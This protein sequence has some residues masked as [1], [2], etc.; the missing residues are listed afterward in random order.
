MNQHR[1]SV[2]IKRFAALAS[3]AA[4][5]LFNAGCASND[6]A[7]ADLLE[8]QLKIAAINGRIPLNQLASAPLDMN[9]EIEVTN[10]SQQEFVLK[11]LTIQSVGHGMYGVPSQTR[12]Y[13]EVIPGGATR[14]V[15][16]WFRAYL[17]SRNAAP[18]EG[19][20]MRGSMIFKTPFGSKRSN[21]LE[22]VTLGAFR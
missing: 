3:F 6:A 21:F 16:M 7:T 4:A 20:T 8:P 2:S 1:S 17:R 19:L 9:I 11:S 10:R 5:L 12:N 22:S 18:V 13:N 14:K 15:D